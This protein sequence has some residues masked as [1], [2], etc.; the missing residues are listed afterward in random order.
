MIYNINTMNRLKILR[1]EKGL[2]QTE[3]AE[4]VGSVQAH[5]ANIENGKRDIDIEMMIRL[6]RALGVKA[7]ELLPE[8]E[9]PETLT[10]EEQAFIDLFR[11]SKTNKSE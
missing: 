7:Y 9:Q 8:E 3:L 10:S 6:A 11:K 2:S 4:K 1:K 5:I